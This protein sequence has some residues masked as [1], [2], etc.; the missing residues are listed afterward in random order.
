MSETADFYRGPSPTS[1]LGRYREIVLG[2]PADVEALGTI[3][4]GLLIHNFVAMSRGL[5]FSAPPADAVAR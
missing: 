5:E 2:L 4:R 3:V 1:D